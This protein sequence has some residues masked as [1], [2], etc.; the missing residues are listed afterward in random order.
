MGTI[1]AVGGG[2]IKKFETLKID[3]EIIRLTG[4]I[5][6][7]VLF[8][9]TASGDSEDYITNFKA[10][11]EKKLKCNIS[12]LTLLRNR[13]THNE[14]KEV[15]LSTD[16]IYVGGGNTL[17]MMK[18]WRKLGLD[19]LLK[20]AY[21]KGIILAGVSAGA[22]CWFTYGHSDSRKYS[23]G[24][25]ADFIK[26]RGLGLYGYIFCPHYHKEK[27]EKSFAEMMKKNKDFIGLAADN[28]AAL[29]IVDGKISLLKSE[30]SG[31]AYEVVVTGRNVT[32][33]PIQQT[34]LHKSFSPLF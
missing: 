16:V 19:N 9:P 27:R 11:Y 17:R 31:K 32:L 21:D 23:S 14:I 3:K 24:K 30:R 33:E 12:V 22:I 4:K 25:G 1:V 13:P 26:V 34:Q 8:I 28:N 29:K 20:K 6:P 18:L 2:D 10:L 5:S 15:I 7:K